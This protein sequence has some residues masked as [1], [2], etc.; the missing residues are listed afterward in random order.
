MARQPTKSEDRV[1]D[2]VLDDT[3]PTEPVYMVVR[4]HQTSKTRYT[5]MS[6]NAVARRP[7]MFVCEQAGDRLLFVEEDGAYYE[8]KLDPDYSVETLMKRQ[9]KGV[10]VTTR[11]VFTATGE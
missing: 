5:S 8:G 10:E 7:K 1:A 3:L 2:A 6:K 4:L 9:N 11:I